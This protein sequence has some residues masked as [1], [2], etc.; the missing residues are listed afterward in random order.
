LINAHPT[1]KGDV[2][3]P[4]T[5]A[6]LADRV[7]PAEFGCLRLQDQ[8]LRRWHDRSDQDHLTV[9]WAEDHQTADPYGNVHIREQLR[10]PG[11]GLRGNPVGG[12]K[13]EMGL[14]VLMGLRSPSTRQ[15]CLSEPVPLGA[16]GILRRRIEGQLD[17]LSHGAAG[18]IR[19]AA[20]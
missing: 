6:E 12:V 9:P 2:R 5:G 3:G 15:S 17:R 19:S 10:E 14:V 13:S 16:N 8:Q 18:G 11:V 4:S 7:G 20:D 1:G